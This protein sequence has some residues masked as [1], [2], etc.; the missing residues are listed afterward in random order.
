M[1]KILQSIA[2]LLDA[3]SDAIIVVDDAGRFVYSNRAAAEALGRTPEALIGRPITEF[4]PAPLGAVLKR[5]AEQNGPEVVEGLRTPSG[6]I[7]D[8]TVVPV[9]GGMAVQSRDV[10]NRVR[11]DESRRE[12][13]ARFRLVTESAPVGVFL[14]DPR[15]QIVYVNPFLREVL[16]RGDTE[17]IGRDWVQW[18]HPD[19]ALRVGAEWNAFRKG[20]VRLLDHVYRFSRSTGEVRWVRGQVHRLRLASS[21]PTGF[22]GT[23]EDV[24]LRRTAAERQHVLA[25]TVEAS[26]DFVVLADEAMRVTHIN[27]AGL[28]LIGLTDA[29]PALHR[30]LCD[31]IVGDGIASLLANTD[32]WTGE[33]ALRHW[34]S[35]EPIETEAHIF[36]VR[37]APGGPRTAVAMVARD[38]RERRR[39][40]ARLEGI[41]ASAMD[42]IIGIDSSG[43]IVVFNQAAE[44]MLR[45]TGAEATG[46]PIHRYIRY[47]PA[48][49][50]RL[51]VHRA[52]GSEFSAEVS[53][54][55][56]DVGGE[57]IA[58]VMVRDVTGRLQIEEQLRQA[59]KMEAVGQLAGGIAHDF[60]NLLTVITAYSGILMETSGD[61]T[62]E[63]KEIS[64]AARRAATLTRQLLSFSRKQLLQ[65]KV[66]DINAVIT[67]VEPMLKRLIGE[68]IEIALSLDA[69][70]APVRIDPGQIEQ[71]LLNLAVNARDA[72]PRGGVLRIETHMTRGTF[73]SL[74][75]RDTGVGMDAATQSRVFEP[76]FTTKEPGRGTGLGLAT[77]Q[78]IMQQC[79]GSVSVESAPGA[80]AAFHIVFPAV[81]GGHV[82]SETLEA[83]VAPQRGSETVLI[84]EDDPAVRELMCT[85]LAANGYSVL[86]ASN[87]AEA[88]AV[89]SA[90]NGTIQLIVTDVVMPSLGGRALVDRL[91]A[92]RPNIRVLYATGYVGDEVVRRGGLD[93]SAN[94]LH[95]PFTADQ[96]LTAVRR[97][98]DAQ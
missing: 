12:S 13:E 93:P 85:L 36:A 92:T 32:R 66:L 46:T 15:G 98:L 22:V 74:V 76:F 79:G 25:A 23:V 21:A 14:A 49:S 31:L 56:V 57:Q 24:T 83:G 38:I 41:I 19:D 69:S 8:V 45:V 5:V 68:D 29:G 96:L 87:G 94:L 51:T 89:A 61:A 10:T 17:L 16:G 34:T 54:S 82:A 67:E 53:V 28:S 11:A 91:R 63:L 80:G 75:V 33:L 97:A 65:P 27:P 9:R 52:D 35:S 7:Y 81:S 78:G 73:V 72:M 43:C 55:R 71:V 70:I 42:A 84:A 4:Y 47:L 88:L 2:P 77:V 50:G 26:A 86:L 3:T 39:H 1:D 6:R 48:S 58:T 37:E 60:N 30:P 20:D 90:T 18:V 64:A 59:S 40:E 62:G 44:A 95:K